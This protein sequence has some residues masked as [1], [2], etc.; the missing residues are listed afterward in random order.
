MELLPLLVL[1]LDGKTLL[2][3]VNMIPVL[4]GVVMTALF[5]VWNFLMPQDF[6]MDWQLVILPLVMGWFFAILEVLV[7]TCRRR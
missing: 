6:R 7:A 5:L 4:V 1:G 2:G 3:E